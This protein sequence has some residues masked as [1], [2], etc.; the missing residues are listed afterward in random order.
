M[1]EVNDFLFS[2]KIPIFTCSLTVNNYCAKT[3]DGMV[4]VWKGIKKHMLSHFV[5]NLPKTILIVLKL[6]KLMMEK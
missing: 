5:G 3:V 1:K 4:L 6:R 2:V